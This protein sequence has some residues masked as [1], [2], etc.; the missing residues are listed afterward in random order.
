MLQDDLFR[1]CSWVFSQ[2]ESVIILGDLN[3]D[4]LKLNSREGKILQDIEDIFDFTCLIQEPTR[5]TPTT[6]T[7]LDVILT[8]KAD[9]FDH[10][11]VIDLGLSDHTLI[12]GFLKPKVKRYPMKIISFRRAVK[13][14]E[15]E[16]K[17]DM[18]EAMRALNSDNTLP[19]DE[20][21]KRWNTEVNNVLDKHM[22][23]KSMRVR[24][25]DVP[26]ITAEWKQAIRKKRKFAKRHKKLQTEESLAELRKWRNA[27]TRIRRRAIRKYWREK[28]EDLKTNPRNFFNAFAP[29]IRNKGKENT[30]IS[31]Q[32]DDKIEH[33]QREV[34]QA[35]RIT[36]E[37]ISG[38]LTTIYNQVLAHGVWPADW[39]WGEW[40]PIHKKDDHL[41]KENY[42]P[43]TILIA[44]D[45]VFEQLLCKQLCELTDKIFDDFMSAYRKSYSC[46]TTLIR[47]VEDW[48]HALD[49]NK[50]VGV[51]S[52]D[53]SKA[54]DSMYP[55]LLL[56]KL[57]AYG[58]SNSS[59]AILE[60]YFKD[61]KNR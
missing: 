48:K 47:L 23:L 30:T 59:L 9:M 39:K 35:L 28:A 21:C 50:A 41:S 38:S 34:A 57:Q 29:F 46:E 6:S 33:D 52:S 58:M 44:V 14:N 15:L 49:H 45:K 37:E 43:V 5:I 22:P 7:L 17:K 27:A 16:M 12:Y 31:L 2:R 54:F 40:I 1:L 8:N 55:P 24:A 51:L 42:R 3:L 56:S 32:V 60:S 26:Y 36:A 25:K 11:G 10:S 19:V 18:E 4:R 20:Q 61:R 53:M 13:M